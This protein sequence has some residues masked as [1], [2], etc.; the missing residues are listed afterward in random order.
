MNIEAIFGVEAHEWRRFV[1]TKDVVR[2][3]RRERGK[4]RGCG[5][6]QGKDRGGGGEGKRKRK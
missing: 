2:R 6:E 5:V 4:E 1:K 3:G